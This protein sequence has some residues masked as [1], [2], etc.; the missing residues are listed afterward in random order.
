MPELS[1]VIPAQNGE[2][3]IKKCDEGIASQA[4]IYWE[5]IFVA[6]ESIRQKNQSKI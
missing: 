3:Y 5:A 4:F 2:K 1:I 6:D